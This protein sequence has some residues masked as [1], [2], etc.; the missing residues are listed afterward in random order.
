MCSRFRIVFSTVVELEIVDL[1]FHKYNR[2][3]PASARASAHMSPRYAMLRSLMHTN[4]R[5]FL[6]VRNYNLLRSLNF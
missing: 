3:N 4:A 5:C 1:R 6:S 2:Q